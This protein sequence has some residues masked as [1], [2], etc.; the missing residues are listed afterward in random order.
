MFCRCRRSVVKVIASVSIYST[1]E[2]TYKLSPN[3]KLTTPISEVSLS[4]CNYIFPSAILS[5]F[6]ASK[7]WWVFIEKCYEF[8]SNYDLISRQLT[9]LY[10]ISIT[11]T[12][13]TC[14]TFQ[15][16]LLPAVMIVLIFFY[17][18]LLYIFKW[19][20]ILSCKSSLHYLFV[21][22]IYSICIAFKFILMG[23]V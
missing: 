20:L 10:L 8:F 17:S 3:P 14:L 4:S 22:G 23:L 13:Q 6:L 5:D 18:I 12:L 7:L 19:R 1:F 9:C 15:C 16:F 11:L 21:L 2:T